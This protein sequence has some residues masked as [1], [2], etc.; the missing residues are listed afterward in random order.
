MDGQQDA[1]EARTEV[2]G[3]SG[4]A[5]LTAQTDDEYGDHKAGGEGLEHRR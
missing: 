4:V 3:G 1:H 2:T 5:G